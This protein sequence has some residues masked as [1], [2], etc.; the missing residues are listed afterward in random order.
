MK[1]VKNTTTIVRVTGFVAVAALLAGCGSSRGAATVFDTGFDAGQIADG[2]AMIWTDPDG[3]QHWAI[4][5]G[6]EGYMTARLNPDG[7]PRCR[8]NRDTVVMK[9]GTVVRTDTAPTYPGS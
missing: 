3:C 7:T 1:N 5:D 2:R 8:D 6:T 9:D 4:D